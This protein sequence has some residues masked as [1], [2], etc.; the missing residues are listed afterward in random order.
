M[1]DT[2]PGIVFIVSITRSNNNVLVVAGPDSTFFFCF[3]S[4]SDFAANLFVY[5]VMSLLACYIMVGS[6]LASGALF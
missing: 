2:K 4:R 1:L 6:G 5:G 3:F